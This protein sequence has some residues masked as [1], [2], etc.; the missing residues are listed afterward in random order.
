[1]KSVRFFFPAL[2][3]SLFFGMNVFGQCPPTITANPPGAIV[4]QGTTVTLTAHPNSPSYQWYKNGVLIPGATQQTCVVSDIGVNVFTVSTPPCDPISAGFTVTIN[5]K[6]TANFIFSPNNQCSP[7]NV[8]FTNQSSG[9]PPLSYAWNFGD[10]GTS[11]QTSPSHIYTLNSH[12]GGE[13]TFTANLTVTSGNTCS[14]SISNTVTVK[15]NPDATLKRLSGGFPSDPP[16]TNCQSTPGAFDLTVGYYPPS[17]Y[18]IADNASYYFSWG[19]GQ[20]SG[21]FTNLNFT[22]PPGIQHTYTTYNLFIITFTVTGVNGCIQTN[23][24]Q[25]Y[26]GSNPSIGLG[27]P[28]NTTGCTPDTIGFPITTWQ[29]NTP[30]TKYRFRYGDSTPDLIMYAPL[31]DTIWHIYSTASCG[32]PL[33]SFKFMASAINLCD[34][35]GVETGSIKISKKPTAQFSTTISTSCVNT[36]V[37]ITN[38]TIPG[39]YIEGNTAGTGTNFTWNFGDGTPSIITNNLS[40]P[41][42]NVQH[43]YSIPGNYIITLTATNYS[44]SGTNCGNSVMTLPICISPQPVSSFSLSQL[45]GCVPLTIIATNTSSTSNLCSDRTFTWSVTKNGSAQCLPSAQNY[46]QTVNGDNATFVFADPGNYS[47]NLNVDNSC[48]VT[49]VTSTQAIVAKTVPRVTINNISTICQGG[50]ID[51]VSLIQNCY[52]PATEY[53]WIFAGGNPSFSNSLNP[54]Q[55]T[56]SAPGSYTVK[57]KA[58]NLCGWSTEVTSNSFIVNPIPVISALPANQT[59]CSG[60]ASSTIFLSSNVTGTTYTWTTISTPGITGAPANGTSNPIPSWILTNS[61]TTAGTV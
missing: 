30:G 39:C 29:N 49:G 50:H 4:C 15:K 13:L 34:S 27:N 2:F 28:G 16:F 1:M 14:N 55:I 3:F 32:Q 19:D 45:T 57:F 18:N 53:L 33:N 22:T 6:P 35:T 25:V 46:T 11:T 10:G 52:D 24:Y 7:M 38:Q 48:T 47:I 61:G 21:P 20:S 23:T 54:G 9:Q 12:G 36:P 31:P 60:S 41:F 43:T 8:Q 59:I 51:P 26:N 5:S 56:Y 17:G 37:I 58:K 42:P 44:V 40:M